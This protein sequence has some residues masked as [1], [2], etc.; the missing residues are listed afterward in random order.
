MLCGS[1][2]IIRESFPHPLG[3]GAVEIELKDIPVAIQ[4]QLFFLF[5]LALNVA[6]TANKMYVCVREC[7]VD[8]T[9][10]TYVVC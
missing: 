2:R 3:E 8:S 4:E 10:L 9:Q 7:A 6:V 1:P 5:V